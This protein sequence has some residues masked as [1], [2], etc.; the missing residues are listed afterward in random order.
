VWWRWP[1]QPAPP[2]P[3]RPRPPL[4][5]SPGLARDRLQDYAT[6]PTGIDAPSTLDGIPIRLAHFGRHLAAVE[7]GLGSLSGLDR[8][9]HIEIYLAA[10][11][12]AR[13]MRGGQVI[14]P[15]EQR[16]RIIT[17]ARFLTDITE[18]GWP[19]TPGSAA[20]R[21]ASL[22]AEV[23]WMTSSPA[24]SSTLT[25]AGWMFSSSSAFTGSG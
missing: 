14:S 4:P 11:A 12:A 20:A 9:R 5:R 10:V 17:L 19:E 3:H 21:S 23:R 16:N 18:W 24:S 13:A 8:Q 6:A 7:P 1:A 15:G 22:R 25:A 2:R